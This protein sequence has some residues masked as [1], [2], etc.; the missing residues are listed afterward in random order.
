MYSLLSSWRRL[1]G[2][3]M[4]P[5]SGPQTS[6]M[7]HGRHVG[8]RGETLHK[9]VQQP[10]NKSQQIRRIGLQR[11]PPAQSRT[12]LE[13]RITATSNSA[14]CSEAVSGHTAAAVAGVESKQSDEAVHRHYTSGSLHQVFITQGVL[15]CL[16]ALSDRL[17]VRRL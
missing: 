5:E 7:V 9:F 13:N 4:G 3:G 14:S 15:Y 1:M 8:L 2:S 6:C 12:S 11:C 16:C 10:F 17:I